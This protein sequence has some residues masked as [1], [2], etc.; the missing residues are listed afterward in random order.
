MSTT[1]TTARTSSL[2]G[3]LL[4]AAALSA[5]AVACEPATGDDDNAEDEGPAPEFEVFIPDMGSPEPDCTGSLGCECFVDGTCVENLTCTDD[6]C[7]NC[8]A[9][10][11]AC[12]C[13]VPRCDEPPCNGICDFDLVCVAGVCEPT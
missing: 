6:L 8:P 1:T 9:G 10:Q 13:E 12:A 3:A 7:H 5:A 11:L 4:A 2:L